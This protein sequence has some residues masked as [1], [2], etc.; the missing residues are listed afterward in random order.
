MKFTDRAKAALS[1]LTQKQLGNS[2]GTV[3][4][5]LSNASTFD[6]QNQLRGITFKAIDKIGM[7]TS[8][9]EPKAV[10]GNGDVYVNHPI[11]TLA[12]NPNPQTNSSD[13]IHLWAMIYE[14]YGETFWYLARG[15]STRRVK[16]VYLLNPMQVELKLSDG[17]VVGYI[18]HKSNGTQVPLMLDEIVHDKRP[19]PFNE[20]RG[21]SVLERASVYVDT[22]ITTSVF[23][24]NYMRN[25]ASP[26]GIVTLPNM[27]KE[28]FKQFAQQWREG[29]EGPHN[30][31][32][33][34]FIR[35]DGVDFKAVG[36]TLK[37]VDQKVTRDMAKEDVL[38]MLEVPKAL[39]GI[40]DGSGQA[41]ANV[42]AVHYIYNK[43]KIDPIMERL[44]RIWEKIAKVG[45][46]AEIMDIQHVSPIPEDK[47][48]RLKRQKDGVNVWLTV[49]E[50]REMDGLGPID[51]G[52][53][54]MPRNAVP[55]A[56]PIANSFTAKKITMKRE[57]S[58][59]EKVLALN[60]E[61]E[62]FRK[63]LVAINDIYATKL[64]TEID[65]FSKKQEA[66]VISK[67]DATNKSFEE[68]LFSIKEDS[69][70]LALLLVPI[71]IELME[72]Q[73]EGVANFISGELLTISPEIREGVN[74]NILRIA[75]LYNQDTI[76]A[77]EQ[78]LAA[79]QGAGES[80]AKLKKRVEQTFSDA[81][82]YRAER[83]ARTESLRASNSTAELTYK[84]SGFT[85]VK[86]FTNPGACAF[87]QTFEG[88]TKTIGSSFANI[89][90]VVTTA[91]GD[92][93]QVEYSDIGTPPLHPNCTC[94]LVPEN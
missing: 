54:L 67:I 65:K 81:Q 1:V 51:G 90:D 48:F 42:E 62:S 3:I 25:N 92:Q 20:F 36:A 87:C 29:Y 26:S 11:I 77:L 7:S 89:G 53:I 80:L 12:K 24:L 41:R 38:M 78:T 46:F 79:G 33:T 35:G 75:G 50:A 82:G 56:A 76:R 71:I 15:E 45:G 23:T 59:T 18:L 72:T 17:E 55:Q 64:K 28:V 6:P 69:T 74:Q 93:M 49:N 58:S 9:Y 68:Y 19:N 14:I 21:M 37:D 5:N 85:T 40:A 34:A 44:D 61:Q 16:E 27:D 32:K 52:S 4:R 88:Q 94:S 30:A 91:Q 2:L 86:W 22:E 39:L 60:A 57:L 10:R 43:E 47:E 83:I 63:D 84:Q 8:V 66:V 73:T 13:F 70:A 31:G